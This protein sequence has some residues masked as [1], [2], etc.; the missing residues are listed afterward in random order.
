MFDILPKET[1]GNSISAN[2][3]G[4]IRGLIAHHQ[5]E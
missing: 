3:Y 4:E 5:N 2:F 1:K